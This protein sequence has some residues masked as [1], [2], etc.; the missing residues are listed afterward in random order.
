[1]FSLPE[2]IIVSRA[3]RVIENAYINTLYYKVNSEFSSLKSFKDSVPV[4]AEGLF[5]ITDP[6][7][8][9]EMQ[10]TLEDILEIAIPGCRLTRFISMCKSDMLNKKSSDLTMIPQIPILLV[11]VATPHLYLPIFIGNDYVFF[12]SPFGNQGFKEEASNYYIYPLFKT[13]VLTNWRDIFRDYAKPENSSINLELIELIESKPS[14]PTAY[15]VYDAADDKSF[16]DAIREILINK[17]G[18]PIEKQISLISNVSSGRSYYD[19][20]TISTESE[21]YKEILNRY[22]VEAVEDSSYDTLVTPDDYMPIALVPTNPLIGEEVGILTVKNLANKKK[23]GYV[24]FNLKSQ[25]KNSYSPD[26]TKSSIII[27]TNKNTRFLIALPS[28]IY[29][30]PKNRVIIVDEDNKMNP[31]LGVATIDESFNIE[32]DLETGTES[33]ISDAIDGAKKYGIKINQGLKE[34]FKLLTK[35][36]FKIAKVLYK[37]IRD[38]FRR[39]D[40]EL[41]KSDSL[42]Y[43][44]KVLNDELDQTKDMLLKWTRVIMFTGITLAITG[45][46]LAAFF[47]LLFWRIDDNNTRVRAINRQVKSFNEAIKRIDFKIDAARQE[48]RYEDVD[49]LLKEKQ[50]LT[51]GRRELIQLKRRNYAKA[52]DKNKEKFGDFDSLPDSEQSSG[53]Y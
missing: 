40:K 2:Y 30:I 32:D 23:L 35:Y 29:E 22:Q 42:E 8:Y 41:E 39:F 3:A 28:T 52:D 48:S 45:N 25:P 21:L 24:R 37:D 12:I 38:F 10:K 9:Y 1:M 15:K 18:I 13:E 19:Q 53:R 34:L 27:R 4:I 26:G 47:A 5:G 17:C 36:P 51:L 44:E 33:F 16:A 49:N 50:M 20:E 11:E 43:R 31:I 7:Y 14:I 6:K 46:V